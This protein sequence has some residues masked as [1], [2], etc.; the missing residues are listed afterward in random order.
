MR[1]PWS[2]L[3][4]YADIPPD[5]QDAEIWRD[6][7]PMLGL[8]VESVERIGDDWIFDL[9]TTA[10]R[11]DWMSVVG[12]AR[13][14]AASARGTLRLPSFEVV[15]SDPPAS[16]LA[17]VEIADPSLCHRYVGRLIVDVTV[18]PSPAWMV[19]RLE[20][21]G[22]R[23]IN[24]VVDVT[25]YVML[26]LGQPLH[27]FDYDLLAG[28]RVIVRAARSGERLVTLDGRE[29]AMFEGALVIADSHGPVALGGIMGGAA[30]EI[31]PT[32]RRVLLESAWFS[33]PAVRQTARALGLRTEGSAR[34]ERGGDP[35]RVRYAAA[36]AA[37]LMRELC[38]G[39]VLRGEIDVYPQPDPPR[40]VSLR[41]PRLGHVLGTEVPE[42]D[43]EEI[44]SR[45]GF[46][47]TRQGERIV[48]E[49]PSHRRDVER[50]EDLI[51]EVARLWGYHRIPE[52]LPT[53]AMAVGHVAPEVEGEA[54][55]REALLRAGLTE[56]LTVSLTHPRDLDRIRVPPDDPLRNLVALQNPL[57][58]EHTHLRSTLVPSLL[59]VLQTNRTRGNADVHIFEIGRVFRKGE[60]DWGERKM[61]GIARIGGVIEGRWNLPPDVVQS[62]FY[63]LK[64]SVEALMEA[65]SLRG[66]LVR[67]EARPWLHPHRAGSLWIDGER[68]GW[69]GE[70]HPEVAE[71][72]DLRGRAYVAEIA[73]APLL[74]RTDRS[75]QYRPLP[76]YPAV[77]RDLAVVVG[78]SVPSGEI[79]RIV[80][81][82]AGP[83]LEACEPFDVYVGHPVP[84]GHRSV[85]FSLRFRDPHRT[86]EAAEVDGV[87]ER[88]RKALRSS[89]G[90][91]IRGA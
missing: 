13:E 91:Q 85:A 69:L 23:S 29:H 10:N 50:E 4:D 28:E 37:Q 7:F 14:V 46:R 76:R 3:L 38:G 42:A 54:I 47:P 68:V 53:E 66:W 27:A 21:C 81:Q 78:E 33:G 40:R 63:H 22:V 89:L 32:T 90:A 39:R 59:A 58:E 36:R 80:A 31:R 70:V 26:E 56:V 75:P 19:D 52:T 71:R 41:L 25:N 48:V 84:P 88:I 51:E 44:L 18:G 30:T 65:L 64:G 62:D 79:Q 15:Q 2:W 60:P 16:D 8:G 82:T 74:A 77:V 5:A 49:V 73:L 34:H 11:P 55:V 17:A 61:I 72:Y 6:R 35:E 43:V 12:I 24:N 67:A 87:M 9:E 20:K 1:F 83:L 86:L 57:T 45:L